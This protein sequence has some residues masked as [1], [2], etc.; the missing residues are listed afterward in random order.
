LEKRLVGGLSAVEISFTAQNVVFCLVILLRNTER[1][2]SR[3]IAGQFFAL[4]AF[5]S[6]LAFL[7]LSSETTGATAVP[8]RVV[9]IMANL[10]AVA[11]MLN[12]G[13]SFGVLIARRKIKTRGLY[14]LVRHPMYLSDVTSRL[15]FSLVHPSVAVFSLSLLSALLYGARA[16]WEE[17]FLGQGEDY[18]SYAQKVRWRF[19]P[20][21]Y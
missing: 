8:G 15:G 1:E 2:M 6:G 12:L 7:N 14:G 3:S 21:V 19:I 10:L 11:S 5:F 9:M 16:A 4:A 17:R 18:R 20:W 13:G